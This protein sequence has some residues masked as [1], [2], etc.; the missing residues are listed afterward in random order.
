MPGGN[1]AVFIPEGEAKQKGYSG[2]I[3]VPNAVIS[4][5]EKLIDGWKEYFGVK[6]KKAGPEEI[7]P[8]ELRSRYN[9]GFD[10]ESVKSEFYKRME[11][12]RDLGKKGI[13][14]ER[15][16]Y[17]DDQLGFA[18]GR[19]IYVKE[20]L[21]EDAETAVV[22]HELGHLMGEDSEEGAY[23]IGCK[24]LEHFGLFKAA[25]ELRKIE[26]GDSRLN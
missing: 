20:G 2:R 3:P 17:S 14:I 23:T 21:S 6:K 10:D 22:A 16:R 5:V 8:P 24:A 18:K 12:Y 15:T 1:K 25:S 9:V 7:K 26:N 13:S 19:K 11:F 4:P